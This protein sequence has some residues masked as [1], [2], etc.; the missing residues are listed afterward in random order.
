MVAHSSNNMLL[1]NKEELKACAH[2][3]TDEACL[4]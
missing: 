2:G 4:C 3:N 1:G